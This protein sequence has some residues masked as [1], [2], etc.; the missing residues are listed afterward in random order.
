M[1]RD[2]IL[3]ENKKNIEIPYSSINRIEFKTPR[4]IKS[5][6]VRVLEI[7]IVTSD[8][9]YSMKLKEEEQFESCSKLFQSVLPDKLEYK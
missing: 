1:D 9:E 2:E 3:N 5:L 4:S 8:K 7:K 6:G